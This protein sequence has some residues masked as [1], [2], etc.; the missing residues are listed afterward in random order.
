MIEVLV[1]AGDGSVLAQGWNGIYGSNGRNTLEYFD[2]SAWH[3]ITPFDRSSINIQVATDGSTWIWGNSFGG[4][5]M[6]DAPQ[7]FVL[8]YENGTTTSIN[9]PSSGP[10]G[11]GLTNKDGLTSVQMLS[12][13]E[14]W[15]SLITVHGEQKVYHYVD[16]TWSEVSL[17]MPAD[18]GG[19]SYGSLKFVAGTSSEVIALMGWGGPYEW[20]G[21]FSV[22]RYSAGAWSITGSTN[23]MLYGQFIPNTSSGWFS[24]YEC[25]QDNLPQD[26]LPAQRYRLDNGVFTPDS[27]GSDL[28]PTEYHLVSEAVQWATSSG[29]MLHYA[30]STMPTA[31]IAA[32]PNA[33]YFPET[34]HNLSGAFRSFYE[35]NGLNFG[36]PGISA[37]ESLALFGL[38]LTEPFAELNPDTGEYLQV[39]YFERVR[40]EYHPANPAP[41]KVLLGRL[42]AVRYIQT[43][44][45][46][47][48][49]N[50]ED[51]LHEGCERAVETNHDL[52]PPF[53]SYWNS[54]GS[55]QI[56]GLPIAQASPELSYTDGATYL[57]LWTE[58]E[59]LEHH[60]ELAGTRYEILLGLLAKEDLRMRGYLE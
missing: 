47:V 27:S 18:S 19:P 10:S 38:P 34:G 44:D 16:G 20:C 56:F 43:Y 59:R 29:S 54:V 17:P 42:G 21:R 1:A 39:Q 53:R 46:I 13:T 57:T 41:Y 4:I 6:F 36:E 9:V 58:R 14:G 30:A 7:P 35:S 49:G 37:A 22:L 8:R 45:S 26:N 15:A 55:V 11:P 25:A 52:C 48:P 33:R 2:G 32:A 51:P 24:S 23:A 40:M 28:V 5:S 3:T 12:R 60:Q 50:A 31:P